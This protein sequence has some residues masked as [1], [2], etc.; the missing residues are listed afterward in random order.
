MCM[1][2]LILKLGTKYGNLKTNSSTTGQ[3][4]HFGLKK[5]GDSSISAGTSDQDQNVADKG[6]KKN[7][8]EK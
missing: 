1:T 4:P 2:V 6:S 3:D 7:Q 5:S 8:S